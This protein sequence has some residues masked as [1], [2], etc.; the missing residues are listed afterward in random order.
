MINFGANYR[1][2]GN[3]TDFLFPPFLFP[4]FVASDQLTT[5][6]LKQQSGRQSAPSHQLSA[7]PLRPSFIPARCLQAFPPPPPPPPPHCCYFYQ[8]HVFCTSP[9]SSSPL[10][11]ISLLFFPLSLPLSSCPDLPSCPLRSAGAGEEQGLVLVLETADL[12]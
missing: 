8:Q 9:A 12:C 4:F 2:K 5:S 6:A 3:G 11:L 10:S 7:S 1:F